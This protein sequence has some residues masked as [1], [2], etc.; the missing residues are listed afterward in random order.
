MLPIDSLREVL[1]CVKVDLI[2]GLK[3]VGDWSKRRSY[4]YVEEGMTGIQFDPH[5]MLCE[6]CLFYRIYCGIL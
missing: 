2:D 3:S 5:K 1:R 6:N 4:M